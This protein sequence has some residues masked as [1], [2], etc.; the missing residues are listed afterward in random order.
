MRAAA[1]SVNI[2]PPIGLPIGGNVRDDNISRGVHDNLLCNIVL[3][4]DN[5]K[6]VCFL[7]LD[8]LG[9][10]YDSCQMIKNRICK[11]TGLSP[12]NILVSTTHTHSGPD[13]I[14]FFKEEIDPACLKYV[15]DISEK[16]SDGVRQ[17]FNQTDD[18][19]M[20]FTK[21]SV[22]DLSFNRRLFMKNGTMV[23]NWEQP[24][25]K[26]VLQE[27]GPIDPDL[28]VISMTDNN[29]KIKALLV[30]FTLHPAVLVGEDWL[31]SRDYI[32]YLDDSLKSQFGN[33]VVI[34]FVNGAEGNINHINY[35]DKKQG[36]GFREAERIG[37]KLG[38]YVI[39]AMKDLQTIENTRLIC[40]SAFV[41]FPLRKISE[42][43]R[44]SAEELLR[45]S[46]GVIT[47]LLDG[48]PDEVYAAQIIKMSKKKELFVET[49]IQVVKLSDDIAIITLPG[50]VFVEFGLKIKETSG[51]K[52]TLVFGLT[53]DCIGYIP[54]KAA[55]RQGGYEIR[56]ATS[57]QLDPM[58]GDMLVI[59]VEQ[60][61]KKL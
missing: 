27:A 14:D 15:E 39:E 34:L 25:E 59:E 53:N 9:L 12:K 58:A 43:E 7:S 36:R 24:D 22:S 50:E 32:H 28:Y 57:S 61:I 55:F 5:E 51:Y 46:E 16:V 40:A 41:K 4:Q 44:Y 19:K 21:T 48:C 10:H 33:D 26:D 35:G 6:R 29:G 2:T 38:F 13:V 1:L 45:K 11:K 49:E 30:N 3:L 31:W 60:L 52:N 56:T 37:K 42:K 23:M 54:T 47:S 20:S 17:V 8:L 18:I